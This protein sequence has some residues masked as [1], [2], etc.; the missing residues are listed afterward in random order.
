[1]LKKIF[2]SMA[3]IGTLFVAL[4]LVGS[5]YSCYITPN[6]MIT[7][8]YWGLG[9][10]IFLVLNLSLLLFWGVL[11]KKY[12]LIPLLAII[13]SWGS[14]WRYSPLNIIPP[15]ATIKGDT[16]KV[17]TYNTFWMDWMKAH[18]RNA[19][20]EILT[21]INSSDADIVCLQEFSY[22]KNND[23]R[24]EIPTINK[25]LKKYPYKKVFF[26][27][28]GQSICS[29]AAIY[30]KYPIISAKETPYKGNSSCIYEID[31]NGRTITIINNHLESNGLTGDDKEV[32]KKAFKNLDTDGLVEAK[33]VLAPK[34]GHAFRERAKQAD[35]IAAKIARINTPLIVCGDFN[36]T[37]QSY[38]YRRIRGSLND[39]VVECGFGPTIT[40]NGKGFWFRIDHIL[41]SSDLQVVKTE[42]GDL[43]NSDHYPLQATFVW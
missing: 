9:F 11:K 19:P 7:P 17:L 3:F 38:V 24:L 32:Y 15:K 29:G 21:Y 14:V 33:R 34:M 41:Y 40:Y 18:T 1:M 36:D 43:K 25:A 2:S 12:L 22:Y 30:S 5:A 37:P 28:D 26:K 13:C 6:R 31:V 35:Q 39:A 10:P 8:A 4:L 20:N 42:R 27:S 23:N 16:L